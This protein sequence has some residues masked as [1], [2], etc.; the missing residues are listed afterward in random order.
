MPCVKTE[1]GKSALHYHGVL[2][3]NKILNLDPEISE[4]EFSKLLKT[5]LDTKYVVICSNVSCE[6]KWSIQQ[7]ILIVIFRV[8]GMHLYVCLYVCID[9]HMY[10]YLDNDSWLL[11]PLVALS[12]KVVEYNRHGAHKPPWV[13]CS[14]CSHCS[15]CSVWEIRWDKIDK[16]N[17]I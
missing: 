3:W 7:S 4:Y 9:I 6:A 10:A 11:H 14:L 1:L 17:F 12:N 5:V 13:S 2:T 8:Y 15:D 16:I